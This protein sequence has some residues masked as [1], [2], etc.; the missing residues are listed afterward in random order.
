MFVFTAWN[1]DLF[2]EEP[3][4]SSQRQ[5]VSRYDLPYEYNNRT[6]DTVGLRSIMLSAL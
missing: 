3:E 4:I 2:E 5:Y 1:K 6:S